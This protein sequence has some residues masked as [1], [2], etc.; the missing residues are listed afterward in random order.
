MIA[1]ALAGDRIIGMVLL[2][3]GYE[4]DYEGRRRSMPPAA[5]ALITHAE[6]LE[7]GAAT[8]WCC[9]DSRSSRSHSEE[10][11]AAS[12]L[13]RSAVITPIDGPMRDGRAR[14]TA[15]RAHEAAAGSC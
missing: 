12:R 8:T 1:E 14:R 6:R 10:P 9:A 2:Q 4:D 15:P 3:P 11:P 5:R 7:D 13:Y